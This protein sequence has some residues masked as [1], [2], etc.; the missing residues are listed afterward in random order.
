MKDAGSSRLCLKNG[1][2]KLGS[3]AANILRSLHRSGPMH[4]RSLHE[5]ELGTPAA[6]SMQLL[7]LEQAGF[8][9]RCGKAKKYDTLERK[10]MILWANVTNVPKRAEAFVRVSIKERSAVRNKKRKTRVASVFG[11]WR[12]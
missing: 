1:A 4:L 5:E 12:P 11:G 2:I 3:V 10:T 7:R 6:I 8:V 9:V